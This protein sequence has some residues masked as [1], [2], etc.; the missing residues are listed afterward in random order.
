MSQTIS[1]QATYPTTPVVDDSL[2]MDAGSFDFFSLEDPNIAVSEHIRDNYQDKPAAKKEEVETDVDPESDYVEEGEDADDIDFDELSEDEVDADD[3]EVDEEPEEE[4]ET[5]SDEEEVDYE[6]YEVTLPSGETIKLAEAV[7]GYK[8]A[9][10]L[11]EERTAFESAR[12]EF[13]EGSKDIG[14]FLDLAKLEALRVIEDYADFDWASLARTDPA[15]YVDNKEFLEKYQERYNEILDAQKTLQAKENA[16]RS[17]EMETKARECVTVLQR[18]ITGWGPELYQ[19][20][21]EYGVENGATPEEMQACVDPAIFKMMHKA[22]Q[23]DK[24]VQTVKAKVKTLVK[25]PSK[26]AKAQAKSTAPADGKKSAMIKKVSTGNYSDKDVSD[27]F[28]M[29]ED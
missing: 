2:V 5:D 24:G 3:E 29:L 12:K 17:A 9:Q 4:P 27:M 15:A 22:M 6:G 1:A 21:M 23:F 19:Q 20:L 16:T 25:Q 11:E 7:K 26:V 28:S 14:A 18:D 10:A 13:E 8:A